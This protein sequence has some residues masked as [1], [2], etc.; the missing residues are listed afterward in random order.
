MSETCQTCRHWHAHECRRF[1]P[2]RTEVQWCGG[3]RSF[4]PEWPQTS[5]HHF[6]GEWLSLPASSLPSQEGRTDG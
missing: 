3:S 1:P 5:G 4:Y 6:C 2:L